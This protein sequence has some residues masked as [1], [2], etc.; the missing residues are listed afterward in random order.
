MNIKHQTNLELLLL[1]FR[2]IVYL[3]YK[4]KNTYEQTSTTARILG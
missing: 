3:L 4:R 2:F 1:Y